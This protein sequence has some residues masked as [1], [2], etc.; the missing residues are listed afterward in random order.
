MNLLQILDADEVT[1]MTKGNFPR[2]FFAVS[3]RAFTFTQK[4]SELRNQN[5]LVADSPWLGA[6]IISNLKGGESRF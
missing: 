4:E 5:S 1:Q 2:P 3:K 6:D